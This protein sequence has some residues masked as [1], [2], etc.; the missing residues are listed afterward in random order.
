MSEAMAYN[1]SIYLM[2]SMPY[3]LL[4]AVGFMVYRGLRQNAAVIQQAETSEHPHGAEGSPCS[5][6]SRV[7][8]F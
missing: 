5:D 8:D 6:P 2:V 7:E 1:Q 3:V 4:G